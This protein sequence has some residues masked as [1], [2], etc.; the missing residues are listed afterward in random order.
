MDGSRISNAAVSLGK[1]FRAFTIDA[2]VDVLS[3]GGTKNGLMFGEAVLV[4][5]PAL[6]VS[7]PYVR[8]QAMQ[9]HS[10]MRFI[11]AQFN[12]LISSDLWSKNANHANQLAKRL[13]TGLRQFSAIQITQKVDAN[14]IFAIMPPSIIPQLQEHGFFY[15]WNDKTSEVRLMCSWDTTENDVD[16]F[17]NQ[18]KI[19]LQ[20]L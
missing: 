2:G 20:S 10:K 1:D 6:A 12:A 17:L 18:V 11:S 15:V 13:E 19:A 9:L 14:G 3:F 7:M 8:K 16:G 4:F 5:N